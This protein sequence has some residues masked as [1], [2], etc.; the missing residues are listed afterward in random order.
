MDDDENHPVNPTTRNPNFTS[1]GMFK[2]KM[3]VPKNNPIPAKKIENL[4]ALPITEKSAATTN[5]DNHIAIS[6]RIHNRNTHDDHQIEEL[7]QEK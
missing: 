3:F 2:R 1:I 5:D 4:Q 7:N 6:N